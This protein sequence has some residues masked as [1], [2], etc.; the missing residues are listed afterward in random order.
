MLQYLRKSY[1]S[2]ADIHESLREEDQN[3]L[4]VWFVLYAL[5]LWGSVRS[6][7]NLSGVDCSSLGDGISEVLMYMQAAGDP[8][9]AFCNCALFCFLD[10]TVR[11]RL[12]SISLFITQSS[13]RRRLLPSDQEHPVEQLGHE[14]ANTFSNTTYL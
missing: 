6:M 7:M 12:F 13:E 4:Y 8:G 3:Y 10:K 11:S 5:R 2:F 9:Q 14:D 1:K